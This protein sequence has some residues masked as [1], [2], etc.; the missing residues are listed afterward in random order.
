MLP[1]LG[2]L[3]AVVPVKAEAGGES[4]MVSCAAIPKD[5]G[6]TIPLGEDMI[7]GFRE[8]FGRDRGR[9]KGDCCLLLYIGCWHSLPG[10]LL[11][12]LLLLGP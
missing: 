7:P 4:I 9:E 5:R 3:V 12:V 8:L 2:G 11:S 1:I 6:P 10:E